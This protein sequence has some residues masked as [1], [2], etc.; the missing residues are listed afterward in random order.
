VLT[1]AP[2]DLLFALCIHGAKH[3]W[4]RLAWVRDVAALLAKHPELDL[5]ASIARAR[6]CGCGRILRLGL[7][8]AQECARVQFPD[9]LRRAIEADAVTAMLQHEVVNALFGPPKPSPRNDRVEPF[10][11]RMRERRSDRLRYVTRT[12]LTPRRHHIEMVALPAA[13]R[14]AYFPLKWGLDFAVLPIW[15]LI[16]P[17]RRQG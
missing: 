10:R 8:V 2:D 9:T 7:A 17:T 14:W 13:L 3:H 6:N 16:R 5:E 11:L 15:S 1:L 4:E 12:W